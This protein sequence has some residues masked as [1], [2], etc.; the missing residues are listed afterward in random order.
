MIH[1]MAP[2]ISIGT[3]TLI[4]ATPLSV[5]SPT[6]LFNGQGVIRFNSNTLNNNGLLAYPSPVTGPFYT[7]PI[8]DGVPE[9]TI[10]QVNSIPVASPPAGQVTGADVVINAAGSSTLTIAAKFVPV[11]TLV[12]L[13]INSDTVVDQ[14]LT[15]APL[16]GVLAS[17]TATCT[18]TFPL[19]AN[20]AIAAASW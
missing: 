20:I 1:L 7:L 16:A 15:C 14:S 11:G 4:R 10:T 8:P 6:P 2:V 12:N 9:V 3:N 13:R 18:A 5:T 17:S 19:G